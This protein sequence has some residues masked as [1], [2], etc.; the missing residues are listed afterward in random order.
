MIENIVALLGKYKNVK[1]GTA[2]LLQLEYTQRKEY[3][4]C[5]QTLT[6]IV[7]YIRERWN[8]L[9]NAVTAMMA[10]LVKRHLT[11]GRPPRW[12]RSRTFAL[13]AGDRGSIPGRDGPKSGK[14]VVTA[15]LRN[16]R[17]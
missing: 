11:C 5:L 17:H 1:P 4:L 8:I 12:R 6:A 7:Q 13:H 16:A 10:H 9:A 14:Q 3:L 15:P 2:T